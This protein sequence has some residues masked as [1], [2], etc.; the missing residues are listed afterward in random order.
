MHIKEL[1]GDA[2]IENREVD[3]KLKYEAGSDALNWLKT[4]GGYANCHGG[5]L[6]FGVRDSDHEVVGF[7]EHEADQQRNLIVN[8]VNQEV[9]PVP[10]MDFSFVSYET[11]GGRRYVICLDVAESRFNPVTVRHK[12][13]AGVYMWRDGFSNPAT[14]EEIYEMAVHSREAVYDSVITD[15]I[16]EPSDFTQLSDFYKRHSGKK[17][18]LMQKALISDGFLDSEGHLS[19][20]ALLFA[21]DSS[22]S[23]AIQLAIFNGITRGSEIVSISKKTGPLTKMID[24]ME[25]FVKQ[26][27]NQA[28]EKLNDSHRLIPAYPARALFEG[29]INSVAHRDYTL[30]GSIQIDMFRDRLEI[31]SPGA[32]YK[33]GDLQKTYD[34][35]SIIS[36]RR[37]PVICNVLV[38]CMVMEASGTGF[39]KI[40]EEYHHVSAAHRPYIFSRNN[41]FTLVLPDLTY[42]AGVSDSLGQ[43]LVF[44]APENTTKHD[45][46]VIRFCYGE[47][48]TAKE[49]ADHLGISDS[50]Y[51]RTKVLGRLVDQGYLAEDQG[52]P[53][54][55]TTR[56]DKVI[57]M[58]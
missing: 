10:S 35:S 22:D 46:A 24:E 36:Q 43:R 49:I 9:Y 7:S 38:R 27:M 28:I 2:N 16:Y 54:K 41:Q 17:T 44:D 51:L 14:Y 47:K 15:K 6:I 21:D 20:G 45:D 13:A 29:I 19:K 23:N 52:R 53:K 30:P 58:P 55:Y 31:S 42:A 12:G 1:I 39:E 32:F 57:L 4:V 8:A 11:K 37:N 18:G 5:R 25:L 26:H 48:R 33:Q 3:Y 34:L 50:A 56:D 40:I